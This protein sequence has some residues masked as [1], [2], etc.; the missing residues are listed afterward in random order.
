MQNT[1]YF[2]TMDEQ[3]LVDRLLLRE[4]IFIILLLEKSQM[5][6]V[7]INEYSHFQYI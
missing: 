4:I 6:G 5:A 2:T 3:R 7:I 1:K